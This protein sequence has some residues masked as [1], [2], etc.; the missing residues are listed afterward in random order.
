MTGYVKFDPGAATN[1]AAK[2]EYTATLTVTDGGA[3]GNANST[4]SRT[5]PLKVVVST[6]E[7]A[8]VINDI[9]FNGVAYA[10][11]ITASAAAFD[12]DEVSAATTV[13]QFKLDTTKH[14]VNDPI[15]A[16][17]YYLVATGT[18]AGGTATSLAVP[19]VAGGNSATFTI[20]VADDGSDRI[21][22]LAVDANGISFDNNYDNTDNNVYKL[23]V[24][25]NDSGNGGTNSSTPIE[26]TV[27]VRNTAGMAYTGQDGSQTIAAVIANG[28]VTNTGTTNASIIQFDFV[29]NI[30]T[31]A[32]AAGATNA[33][34]ALGITLTDAASADQIALA[35]NVVVTDIDHPLA[36]MD[37]AAKVKNIAFTV[38]GMVSGTT[39]TLT[40]PALT[41]AV[42]HQ[43]VS[44][45]TSVN[46]KASTG[47]ALPAAGGMVDAT[48]T[49][50]FTYDSSSD[51]VMFHGPD[52]VSWA[53]GHPYTEI[54]YAGAETMNAAA[55][56]NFGAKHN[57]EAGNKMSYY[58]AVD[59]TAPAGTNG[60]FTWTVTNAA[61][62]Q[63]S[64][65]R[66]VTIKDDQAYAGN[67]PRGP[68]DLK[69]D[70][71][72]NVTFAG[73]GSVA[74]QPA[75]LDYATLKE[76]ASPTNNAAATALTVTRT[77]E[78]STSN[79][80]TLWAY[81]TPGQPANAT[82]DE[83]YQ[84]SNEDVYAYNFAVNNTT[85]TEKYA[86][87]AAGT[88]G[89][90]VANPTADASYTSQSGRSTNARTDWDNTVGYLGDIRGK[91]TVTMIE[92]AAHIITI[93]LSGLNL[94]STI[95][96]MFTLQASEAFSA[97]I[98]E[99]DDHA[100][101]TIKM[102]KND[103]NN[104]FY[105][106]PESPGIA[107]SGGDSVWT[108]LISGPS[109]RSESIELLQLGT[110]WPV[111]KSGNAAGTTVGSAVELHGITA[112][113]Y[114]NT[115]LFEGDIPM[116]ANGD[117]IA[118]IVVENWSYDIFGVREMADIFSS[119]A[120][121]KTE[122]R[123]YLTSPGAGV[124]TTATFEGS[125]RAQLEELNASVA[126]AT[127]TTS[128]NNTQTEINSKPGQFLLYALRDKIDGIPAAHYRLTTSVGGIFHSSN[129]V[130]AAGS[131]QDFYPFIWQAGDKITIGTNF[132][133]ADVNAGTLFNGGATSKALGDLPFKFVITLV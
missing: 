13:A 9:S 119:T 31:T 33:A 98:T 101:C 108:N 123:N 107:T 80:G 35:S 131:T 17:Q 116:A 94:D 77:T 130:T 92:A 72:T 103:F 124:A 71:I 54:F 15:T 120:A 83:I 126:Q 78:L 19:S 128:G 93:D 106:K 24:F 91:R 99:F 105:Y 8:P 38:E 122:I 64:R 53:R 26:L 5:L 60:Y 67:T 11:S 25:A 132:K 89:A 2:K 51:K 61:G 75:A 95:T 1:Y 36:A 70:A 85:W 43:N 118:C 29:A 63:T 125:V 12:F 44:G 30:P 28:V 45:Q 88:A 114:K 16:A 59:P 117:D 37:S 55:T 65:T 42:S 18:A 32:P 84:V 52:A 7:T 79:L 49:F 4:G 23:A 81:A 115:N 10:G 21:G 40:M 34:T 39:Y 69:Q 50:V 57:G 56:S 66:L 46:G 58:N 14:G 3:S 127:R 47:G 129:K 76:T 74:A 48:A 86:E 97:T 104:I 100:T 73:S 41:P 121:M 62:G 113:N 102:S 27:T 82:F 112:A 6:D 87:W 110:N 22:T 109:L 20:T 111:M 96:Q 68:P 90:T 133:H